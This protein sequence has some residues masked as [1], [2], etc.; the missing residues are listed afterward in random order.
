M[1]SSLYKRDLYPP[2]EAYFTGFLQVDSI[3][4]IYYEQSGNPNGKPVVFVHGGPGGGSKPWC[5]QFFDP[6]KYRI[7][8]FDQR[9]CG[10]S[11]PL[12]CLENNTTWD[13]VADME[14]IRVELLGPEGQWLI[15]G[16]SWGSTLSLIYAITYPHAVTG[17]ILRGIYSARKMEMDWSYKQGASFIFPEAFEKFKN[18]IPLEEQGDLLSAYY[19]RLIG[20]DEEIKLKYA[21]AWC[22]W[23]SSACRFI[24]KP[25]D[26]DWPKKSPLEALAVARIETHYFYHNIWLESDEWIL[27]NIHKIAHIPGIT[28]QGRYD[29]VCP[30]ITAYQ[31]HQKWPKGELIYVNDAGHLLSEPG[32]QAGLVEAAERF[33]NL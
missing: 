16:G 17:L 11:T 24:T 27:D 29:I 18:E 2:I 22:V 5:R 30:P 4:N 13:L 23:E 8:L 26:L 10:K 14:R 28:L 33:K 21:I 7:I 20:D 6:D 12:H 31:I 15:F 19:K 3:H 25:E 32:I 1:T 9:G